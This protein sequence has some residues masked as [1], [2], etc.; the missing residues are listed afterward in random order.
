MTY[1]ISIIMENYKNSSIRVYHLLVFKREKGIK[2][3]HGFS[4]YYT[5]IIALRVFRLIIPLIL[6]DTLWIVYFGGGINF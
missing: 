4:P 3:Q 1:K 2:I 5:P 6:M